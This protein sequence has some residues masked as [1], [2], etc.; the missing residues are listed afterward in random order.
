MVRRLGLGKNNH[1]TYASLALN[2]RYDIVCIQES[3]VDI[4]DS[5]S[6]RGFKLLPTMVRSCAK[7]RSGG[8]A[9]FAREAIF[10]TIKVV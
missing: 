6:F 4:Y 3:H 7:Y 1:L 5:V 10:D 2:P 9:I 8:I